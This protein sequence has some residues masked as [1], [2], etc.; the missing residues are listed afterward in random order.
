MERK[1]YIILMRYP[2]G[3]YWRIN[4]FIENQIIYLFILKR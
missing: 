1:Y 4:I 3:A 2:V